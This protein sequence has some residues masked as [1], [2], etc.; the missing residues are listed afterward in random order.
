MK[1]A[2]LILLAG[3]ASAAT[4]PGPVPND[5]TLCQVWAGNGVSPGAGG[6]EG[7]PG[8]G[9]LST[10]VIAAWG[11]P[12]ERKGD[13]WT[14]EWSTA[15]RASSATL[16]FEKHNL[17]I[18][19][20]PIGGSW[21]SKIEASGLADRKCWHYDLRQDEAT[22]DGCLEQGEVHDCD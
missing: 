14:Y 20:K 21:L 22:C 10:D 16:T 6:F 7:V 17:C 8:Y 19:S 9:T 18:G 2:A 15:G 5:D 1:Y 13:V 12:S 4:S 11:E 3:C